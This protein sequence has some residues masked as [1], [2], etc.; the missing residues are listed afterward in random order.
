MLS[1]DVAYRMF[2]R[3]DSVSHTVEYYSPFNKKKHPKKSGTSHI[4]II[5]R[6][7]N[8]VGA[9]TSINA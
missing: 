5:D 4:S 2:K 9:T 1:D 6:F 3:I 8:A 7:G